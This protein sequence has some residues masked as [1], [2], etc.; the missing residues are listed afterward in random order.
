MRKSEKFSESEREGRGKKKDPHEHVRAVE[1]IQ[2]AT[3][4]HV[5]EIRS[6]NMFIKGSL[7][8]LL[9]ASVYAEDV[10][11]GPDKGGDK[12]VSYPPR[13][14]DGG[15]RPSQ[16]S[17]VK[18]KGSR[19]RGRPGQTRKKPGQPQRKWGRP[20]GNNRDKKP[21]ESESWDTA[22]DEWVSPSWGGDAHD[23]PTVYP[24]AAPNYHQVCDKVS[25]LCILGHFQ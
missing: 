7:L 12:N 15:G 4:I 8:V 23:D 17:G 5:E 11:P 3:I 6:M 22:P 2:T 13:R 18:W 21:L 24:T 10:G 20:G 16:A 1:E 25:Y 19:G 14:W 9:V